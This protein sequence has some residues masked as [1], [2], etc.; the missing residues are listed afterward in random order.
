MAAILSRPQCVDDPALG[1]QLPAPSDGG[2]L[3]EKTWCLWSFVWYGADML[4]TASRRTASDGE[5]PGP[6]FSRYGDS[7]VK[8]KTVTR[9]SLSLTW[10]SLY[11]QDNIF[12]LRWPPGLHFSIKTIFPGRACI[13]MN[14]LVDQLWKFY[15]FQKQVACN[16]EE[17]FTLIQCTLIRY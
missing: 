16:L 5:N 14:F 11:W 9:P 17:N 7:H 2:L 1:E 13:S 6:V 12:I 3:P 10:G 4:R 8:D 15:I